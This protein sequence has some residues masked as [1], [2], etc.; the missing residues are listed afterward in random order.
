[1][2]GYSHY[3]Q[4]DKLHG[5]HRGI[6]KEVPIN[7][8]SHGEIGVWIPDIMSEID[9]EYIIA[10]PANS[11]TGGY[12]HDDKDGSSHYISSCVLPAKNSNV[13]VF[14]EGGDRA[15]PRYTTSFTGK[16]V[17]TPPENRNVAEPHR[18]YTLFKSNEG[19]AIVICDSS[20]QARFE[21]TGKKRAIKE[22]PHGD[23]E[24]VYKI[25]GN[26][27]SIL[28]DERDGKEKLLIRTHKG[29]FVNIDIENRKLQIDFNSDIIINSGGKISINADNGITVKSNR[30]MNLES[31]MNMSIL[32]G[33]NTF[34][35]AGISLHIRSFV[36]SLIDGI[37]TLINSG[38]SIPALYSKPKKPKGSR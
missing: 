27:T 38:R 12:S 8:N 3:G 32:G 25:D 7:D 33:M 15:E 14:F 19:R 6:V 37:I 5:W 20:D 4:Q 21:I 36:F 30:S 28:L 24:S 18:V 34:I 11:F 26:M 35:T 23:K 10:L 31:V 1:M 9:G 22:P 2:S 13:M 16:Y 17:V 29:D